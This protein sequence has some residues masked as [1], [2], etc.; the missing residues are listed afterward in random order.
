[1]VDMLFPAGTPSRVP[2]A[3]ITGTNGKT[4]TSRML[5]HIMKLAG[6][7]VG[8]AS[9]DGV[10]IDGQLTVQGDMTGP[11]SAKMIL[12]DPS[13][14]AAVLET[15]R[16]GLLRRGMGYREANVSACLNVAADHLGLRGIDTVE[17]LAEV[18]RIVIEVAKDT[19]VLNADDPLCLKMADYSTA[20]RLCYITMNHAHPLVKEHIQANGLAIVLEQGM[21]GHMIALYDNGQHIPLLWT[22]LI[23][24][25]L[26]G[27][28]LH[29]VQNAMFAAALA[30]S[31]DINLENIRHGLRTFSASY[32][33]AP[34][35]MNVYDEHPFKVILDYAHNP[36]AVK[37]ICQVMDRFEIP[38]RKIVVLA[39][40][41]DRRDEDIREIGQIAAGHFQHYICR[42][43][44][45]PR[46]RDLDEVPR[47]LQQGLR[48]AGVESEQIQLIPDEQTATAEALALARP[49]DLLL[50]LGDVIART[51]KQI[52]YFKPGE[53]MAQDSKPKAPMASLTPEDVGSFELDGTMALIRDERGVRL[54]RES[55]D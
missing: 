49:G 26:E 54:A 43:D 38:G 31:L 8:L 29:N 13:V 40:P 5:A 15:A 34:G 23:P 30:Y 12:R 36:A 35:R 14:D 11:A 45:N 48:Q 33:Q 3:A 16:G 50:I 2:I 22:H 19:A 28:A 39:A 21:N 37:T 47:L 6:H 17:R 55:E 52:I 1:V 9:T 4:T 44:D 18:K 42:R 51:W 24:A 41:G 53:D 10:Y 32:F 27:R 25:T 46:G 7:T 20:D